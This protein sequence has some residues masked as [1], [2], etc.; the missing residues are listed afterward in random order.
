MHP[1]FDSDVFKH[2]EEYIQKGWRPSTEC[3]VIVT[4]SAIVYPLL[5]KWFEEHKE[6]KISIGP[7]VNIYP[8]GGPFE[9]ETKSRDGEPLIEFLFLYEEIDKSKLT[10]VQLSLGRTDFIDIGGT[11]K[12][13]H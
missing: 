6:D 11:S 13:I 12:S 3:S 10:A 1:V 8:Y 2:I 5:K 9:L 4:E 7:Y